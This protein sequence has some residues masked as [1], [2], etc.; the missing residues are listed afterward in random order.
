MEV[1]PRP[2]Y[3][4]RVVEELYA[5]SDKVVALKK[6]FGTPVYNSLSTKQQTLLVLQ[7]NAMITYEA[8]LKAR[9]EDFDARATTA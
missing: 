3:Q 7:L 2:D 8:V 6:F 4:Q 1:K 5:L 9:V